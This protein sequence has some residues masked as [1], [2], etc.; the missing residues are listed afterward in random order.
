MAL[1]ALKLDQSNAP[2][3]DTGMAFGSTFWDQ[4]K[5]DTKALS[6]YSANMG[7]KG[8]Q[9]FDTSQGMLGQFNTMF[10]PQNFQ[11]TANNWGAAYPSI[12]NPNTTKQLGMW[13][14]YQNANIM[15]PLQKNLQSIAGAGVA[16]GRGG[17]GVAGGNYNPEG[18]LQKQAISQVAG[19]AQQNLTNAMDWMFKA[20]GGNAQL[21]QAYM[22]AYG[23]MFG[24]EANM[25]QG[26][27]GQQRAG[28]EDVQAAQQNW[29]TSAGAAYGTDAAARN[30]MLRQMP[31]DAQQRQQYQ[32]G[33]TDQATQRSTAGNAINQLTGYQ[34]AAAGGAGL[35]DNYNYPM[36]MRNLWLQQAGMPQPTGG[37]ARAPASSSLSMSP[38]GTSSPGTSA[39][40][41]DSSWKYQ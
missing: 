17:F 16:A 15:N 22:S 2:G 13:N 30:A 21:L 14:Q 32:Q 11:N 18:G 25:A 6:A 10:S 26:Y 9:A 39:G 34:Q 31:L 33:Q 35:G 23:Q 8:N 27:S 3:Q 1:S 4:N 37:S 5:P 24:N 38:Y 19:G 7:Q 12:T 28:L 20:A 36:G 41:I 29:R 40:A